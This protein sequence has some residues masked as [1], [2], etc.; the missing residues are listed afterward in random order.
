MTL[1]IKCIQ[2]NAKERQYIQNYLFRHRNNTAVS[3][4]TIYNLNLFRKKLVVFDKQQDFRIF[5]RVWENGDFQQGVKSVKDRQ[6]LIHSCK[7]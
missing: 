3:S 1:E 7:H 6:V 4:A 5:T 2:E